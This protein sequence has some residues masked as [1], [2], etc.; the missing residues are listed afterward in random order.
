MGALVTSACSGSGNDDTGIGDLGPRDFATGDDMR[1]MLDAGDSGTPPGMDLGVQ[2]AG[3]TGGPVD[4]GMM[5]GGMQ[6]MVELVPG[7]HVQA[8]EGRVRITMDTFADVVA[9]LGAGTRNDG[10]TTRSYS[11][12]LAGG[13]ELIV[14]FA[15]TNLDADDAPPNDVD[16]TD[17]VLWVTVQGTFMGST[18][19]GIQVGSAR[20]EVETA[21]GQP[22]NTVPLT[23]PSGT[24]AQYFQRGLLVAY[25]DNSAVRTLTVT[26]A[27]P[28]NPDGEIDVSNGRLRFMGGD[29]EGFLSIL[30]QGSSVSDVRSLL[31]PPDAEGVISLQGQQLETLSYGFIGIELFVLDSGPNNILFSSVHV[32]YYGTT[33]G[34]Q[35]IGSTRAEF[36]NFLSMEGYGMGMPVPGTP[37][38]I[39]YEA[40]QDPAVGVTYSMDTPPRVTTITSPL[41]AMCN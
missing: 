35:G 6:G 5:D 39:C 2:D 10:M 36:E 11:W 32:P 15:N 33:S 41:L 29:V 13:V 16:D 27:Y 20:T 30:E 3:D 17:R 38:V 4:L 19:E 23:N 37:D 1:I 22:A 40:G 18:P 21:Y 9:T 28:Q 26:R 7:S 34:G 31:G 12:T 24:L 14:W 8:Q 25:D